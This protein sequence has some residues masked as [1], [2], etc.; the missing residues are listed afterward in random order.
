[1]TTTTNVL[2][3]AWRLGDEDGRAAAKGFVPDDD[4]ATFCRRLGVPADW[5]S[6]LLARAEANYEVAYLRA[7][8]EES[9]LRLWHEYGNL[10]RS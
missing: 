1:M 8:A 4:F 2:R 6:R 3:E 5:A 7:L 9:S 10:S